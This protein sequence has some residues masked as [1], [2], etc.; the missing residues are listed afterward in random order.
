MTQIKKLIAFV[1]VLVGGTVYAKTYTFHF[2]PPKYEETCKEYTDLYHA[3]K[4]VK[5]E[6]LAKKYRKKYLNPVFYMQYD[7]PRIVKITGEG[8][9]ITKSSTDESYRFCYR[10]LNSEDENNSFC[11]L[12]LFDIDSVKI[13]SNQ[14]EKF[15]ELIANNVSI[16]FASL[17]FEITNSGFGDGA[18]LVTSDCFGSLSDSYSEN[19]PRLSISNFIFGKTTLLNYTIDKSRKKKKKSSSD[20]DSEGVSRE[21]N[22]NEATEAE[23]ANREESHEAENSESGDTDHPTSEE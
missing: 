19:P 13:P 5:A 10:E 23:N 20:D 17:T 21:S 16:H 12:S 4:T 15:Q 7:K 8:Y 9:W 3:G 2:P 11:G 22:D 1:L 14:L 18:S 6:R